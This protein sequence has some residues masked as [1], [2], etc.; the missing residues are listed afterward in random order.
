MHLNMHMG[1]FCWCPACL[2]ILGTHGEGV[3]SELANACAAMFVTL[4]FSG[5]DETMKLVFVTDC[6][7]GP[8]R[9]DGLD[10]NC[11]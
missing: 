6:V 3:C 8:V 7:F 1:V 10:D 9:G 11:L 5:Q 2:R 4:L